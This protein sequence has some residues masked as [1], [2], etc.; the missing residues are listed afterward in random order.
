MKRS[1]RNSAWAQAPSDGRLDEHTATCSGDLPLDVG[2]GALEFRFPG[3]GRSDDEGPTVVR[4]ALSPSRLSRQGE[5]GGETLTRLD[6]PL[7]EHHLV[8][9]DAE[10]EDDE[11]VVEE[12]I[13]PGFRVQGAWAI[14]CGN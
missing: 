3:P 10:P 6:D 12:G 4:I 8:R 5:D 7:D 13:Q 1:R 11:R 9:G 2:K 14:A